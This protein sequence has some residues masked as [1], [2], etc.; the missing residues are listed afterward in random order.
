MSDGLALI[1]VGG[2]GVHLVDGLGRLQASKRPN[3][4]RGPV[5]QPYSW[6][7]PITAS[8]PCFSVISV[9]IFIGSW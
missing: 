7:M 3:A 5:A 9:I 1:L 2:A 6:A 8:M 4:F